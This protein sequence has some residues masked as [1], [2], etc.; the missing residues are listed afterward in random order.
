MSLHH[1][2]TLKVAV[3]FIIDK[4][5]NYYVS[6]TDAAMMVHATSTINIAKFVNVTMSVASNNVAFMN[7][8][9]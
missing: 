2:F 6:T 3:N 7:F 9:S 8:Y 5:A 1:F 4:I